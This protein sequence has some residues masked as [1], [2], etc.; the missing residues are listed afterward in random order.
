VGHA[1]NRFIVQA[2]E[3]GPAEPSRAGS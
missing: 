3:I 1:P 2:R